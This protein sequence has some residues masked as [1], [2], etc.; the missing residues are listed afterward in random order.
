MCNKIEGIWWAFYG[1]FLLIMYIIVKLVYLTNVTSQLVLINKFLGTD[2]HM[3][4][5]RVLSK[6]IH[7]ESWS[8]SDRF[9][10]VT[11]CDIS[12]RQLGNIHNYTLQCS[13]PLNLFNEKIYIFIWFWFAMVFVVTC[14][15]LVHWLWT[16]VYLPGHVK[17]VRQRLVAMNKLDSED[18]GH[19]VGKFVRVYLRRDGLFITRMVAKN[20]SDMIAA[21]LLCGLYDHFKQ[22]LGVIEEPDNDDE[23][24]GVKSSSKKRHK[25]ESKKLLLN[26]GI[27][28]N[29]KDV[30]A[31]DVDVT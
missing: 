7:G 13:L 9:P 19:L 16:S 5:F 21:L 25:D 22:N 11:L 27:G 17:T 6:M 26:R 18:D 8:T 12:V 23:R 20:S 14:G 24:S 15:S 29:E 10:R 2:Y 31:D 30:E 3:Y 1:S 28:I 4:G